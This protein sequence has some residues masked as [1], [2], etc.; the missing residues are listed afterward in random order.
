MRRALLLSLG[1]LVPGVVAAQSS[2]FGVRGLGAP[3]RGLTARAVGSAG[4]FGLFDPESSVNPAALATL[5]AMTATFTGVQDYRHV[6]NPAGRQSVRESRF[7]QL[8]IG[9]PIKRFPMVLGL[10]FSN[11]TS[12]DFTLASADTIV[13]RG[14]PVPVSDT[15]A[16]RGGLSDLR[17]AASY[18][19]R[20]NW[21]VGGSFHVIT[22]TNRLT[23]VRA[24]AD[25]AF[26]P[27]HQS[28]EISYAGVGLDVGMIRS[29]GPKFSVAAIART[30]GRALVDRDSTRV[31][32]VDLPY[33]FGLGFRWR[34]SPKLEVATQGIYRTWSGAN[35]DL[36][37]QGGT[38]SE[39]TYQVA[40]GGE[41]TPDPR[42]PF[43]RPIRF[44]ARYGTLPFPLVPGEQPTEFG[45]SLGTGARFAQ[46]RAGVDLSLEHVWRSAGDYSERAFLVT[47]GVSIRP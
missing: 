41:L 33:T 31:S 19:I 3:G 42:R 30:D 7:P 15:F 36:L 13:L 9:G 24:F 17:F 25:P 10:S 2:Q 38:G 16:S 26:Q 1:L 5:P 22:G 12:R 27:A 37:A 45:V 46:Q 6:E 40:F 18:R 8:A 47:V 28:S 32:D 14:V 34:P 20:D 39:N 29:F 23:S 11:Y 44:G 35:S 43:R 4:A 21:I